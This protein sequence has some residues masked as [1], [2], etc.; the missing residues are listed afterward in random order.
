MKRHPNLSVVSNFH[1]QF[2][3]TARAWTLRI[4]DFPVRRKR[5]VVARAE[6]IVV[7]RPVIDEATGVRADHVERANFVVRESLEVDGP[8]GHIRSAVP[9]V[10]ARREHGELS[11]FPVLGQRIQIGDKNGC[12]ALGFAP[13]GIERNAKPGDCRDD[14]DRAADGDGCRFGDEIASIGWGRS[15]WFVHAGEN[16]T[17]PAWPRVGMTAESAN[18]F[19]RKSS[20]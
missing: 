1:G 7:G 17:R 16:V 19:N 4:E 3:E 13:Q 10:H 12:T 2:V 9:G 20:R 5:A 18:R 14:Y 6:I 8:N 11:R 15:V